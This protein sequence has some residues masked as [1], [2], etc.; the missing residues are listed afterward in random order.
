MRFQ[1][2]NPR[3]N[4]NLPVSLSGPPPVRLV[5]SP[6]FAAEEPLNLTYCVAIVAE[7]LLFASQFMVPIT[8]MSYHN[9]GNNFAGLQSQYVPTVVNSPLQSKLKNSQRT[10]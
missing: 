9:H 7:L 6:C 8:P 10:L 2:I 5:V 4:Q 1:D 3:F